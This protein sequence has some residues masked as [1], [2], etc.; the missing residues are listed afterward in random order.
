MKKFIGIIAVLL[1][2][3]CAVLLILRIWDIKIVEPIDVMRSGASLLILAIACLFLCVVYYTFFKE[4]KSYDMK[5]G[6]RAH[7]KKQS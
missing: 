5:K 7:P 4:D 6:N 3:V 1:G 2:I